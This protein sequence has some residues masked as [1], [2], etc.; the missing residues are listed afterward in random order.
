MYASFLPSP[1]GLITPN[2][3]CRTS[4]KKR[5]EKRKRKI[6]EKLY[7]RILVPERDEKIQDRGGK[8]LQQIQSA[9][10]KRD[11]TCLS[12]RRRL[13]RKIKM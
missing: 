4:Y 7:R 2:K 12:V 3:R 6:G 8:R 1:V 13:V 9:L 10:E 5:K 11:I